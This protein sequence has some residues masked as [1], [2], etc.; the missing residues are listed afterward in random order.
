[1][2]VPVGLRAIRLHLAR[3]IGSFHYRLPRRA[4]A[5]SPS[6]GIW[7]S[8]RRFRVSHQGKPFSHTHKR[9]NAYE[10]TQYLTYGEGLTS[11]LSSIVSAF[12]PSAPFIPERRASLRHEF[13]ISGRLAAR[14]H[15][16]CHRIRGSWPVSPW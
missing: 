3:I 4:W 1:D 2:D 7:Q 10:G 5:R 14:W 6:S 12:V 15:N 8:K 9:F 11:H 13:P 16:I